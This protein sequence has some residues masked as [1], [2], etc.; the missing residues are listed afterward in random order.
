MYW[1]KYLKWEVWHELGIRKKHHGHW[2]TGE[3]PVGQGPLRGWASWMTHQ[4]PIHF[5]TLRLIK[6]AWFSRSAACTW[7]QRERSIGPVRLRNLTC[8]TLVYIISTYIDI[9]C[10]F[11]GYHGLCICMHIYIYIYKL[12]HRWWHLGTSSFI[13]DHVNIW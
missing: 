11:V 7:P 13:I 10:M 9:N 1:Q 8:F 5:G 3:V 12:W 4:L 6:C 2:K